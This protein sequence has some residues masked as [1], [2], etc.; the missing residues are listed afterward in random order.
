MKFLN[1]K[2]KNDGSAIILVIV[3]LVLL[4]IVGFTFVMVSRLDAIG[5]G[6]SQQSGELDSAVDYLVERIADE[7]AADADPSASG[8]GYDYPDSTHRWLANI[9]PYFDE[10]EA[11]SEGS[12]EDNY[13]KHYKWRQISDVFGLLG[14]ANVKNV[15]VDPPG[16]RQ[17]ID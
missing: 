7:I 10:Q 17:T 16:N 5:A 15:K 4:A 14:E 13:Y 12:S 3:M 6:A 1:K 2:H 9:E 11:L 8:Y